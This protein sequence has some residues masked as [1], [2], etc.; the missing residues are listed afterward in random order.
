MGNGSIFF[1]NGGLYQ[2]GYFKRDQQDGIWKTYYKNGLLS[3][4]GAMENGNLLGSWTNYYEN[5][6]IE[7]KIEYLPDN[8][9][10]IEDVWDIKGTQLVSNGNG[11][12]K[13]FSKTGQLLIIGQ[14]ENGIKTGKWTIYFENGKKKEEGIY[15]NEIYRIIN[16]W[17][18]NGFQ[19]IIEGEGI[20]KAYY[21]DSESILETGKVEKGLREG[22][23]VIYHDSSNNVYQKQNYKNGKL[24]GFQEI[25]FES[26][27]PYCSGEMI[28]GQKEGEWNWYFENGNISSTVNFSEGKKEGEQIIW[29]EVGKIT[30]K[31][32]YKNGE[33]LKEEIL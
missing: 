21:P 31:E 28:D 33:L 29:G 3:S 15:E 23:W 25:F 30:K 26:N 17:D 2:S 12:Y 22:E 6:Q 24:T 5:G 14:V 8:K 16:S 1:E 19:I 11:L 10:L 20:Y 4:I 27:Q 18:L 13:T 32:Y 9:T 7:S